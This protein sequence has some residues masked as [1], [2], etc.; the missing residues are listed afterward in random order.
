METHSSPM[1]DEIK[2]FLISTGGCLA[3]VAL[4][5][6]LFWFGPRASEV[7]GQVQHKDG[8]TEQLKIGW[9]IRWLRDENEQELKYQREQHEKKYGA[10]AKFVINPE[11]GNG[12]MDIYGAIG[13]GTN[14]F[15]IEFGFRED[16][17]VVWRK[18]EK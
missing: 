16:G 14:R 12:V 6:A 13:V 8:L 10:N 3:A 1:K 18:V 2:P 7:F 5:F 4:A 17:V 15:Q 11:L 9:S